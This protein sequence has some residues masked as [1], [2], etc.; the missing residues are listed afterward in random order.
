MPTTVEPKLSPALQ[1]FSLKDVRLLESP[2]KH[3][4]EMNNQ[5]LLDL[6]PDRLL[7]RFREFNGL[8]PKAPVYGGWE[9]MTIS[10]H[11]LGHYLT[12]IAQAYASTGEAVFKE[13]VDYI[14]SEL[15]L[16]Q[17]TR[18]T[19]F[20][21]AIP[22]QDE[23][24]G[25]LKNGIL[26]S[27]GFDLNGA[28]VPWYTQHKIIAG[29][30]DAYELCDSAEALEIARKFGYWMQDITASL[31]PEQWQQ[32]LACEHGG[33]NESF[34]ELYQ[35]TGEKVFLEIAEK[36]YHEAIL[37]PL[38]KGDPLILVGKHCNTQVPKI[39][40]AERIHALTG[41]ESFGTISRTFWNTIVHDHT[42]A[43]GGNSLNEHLGHPKQL[44]DRLGKN[45]A[46]TC[47][48][49]NL[50]KLTRELFMLQPTLEL[51]DFYERALYNHILAS[52]N[53]TTGMVCYFVPLGTGEQKEYSTPFDSFWCCV[54]TGIENHS[55]Y[56]DSIY[57]HDESS[58]WINLF[59]PSQLHWAEKQLKLRLETKFPESNKVTITI[60][61]APAHPIALNIRIPSWTKNPSF[62]INKNTKIFDQ[63]AHGF[64]VVDRQWTKGDQLELSLP[65]T[66]RTEPIPGNP[67]CVAFLYG[68]ILLASPMKPEITD[69]TIFASANATTNSLIEK[70]S[71]HPLEFRSKSTARPSDIRLIPFYQTHD[72]RYQVYF[73]LFTGPDWK[74]KEL[75]YRAQQQQ[76]ADL[77]ART[78]DHIQLGEMQPERDHNLVADSSQPHN[79]L[80]IKWRDATDGGSFTFEMTVDPD[81]SH[82]LV[83]RS[84]GLDPTHHEYDIFIDEHLLLH[85]KPD[86]TERSRMFDQ[87][88]DIRSDWTSGKSKIAIKFQASSGKNTC[89]L[90]HATM[91][92]K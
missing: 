69:A 68:P 28:W 79:W 38:A 7:S 92:R 2:F 4:M 43:N 23:V 12:A 67:S 34:A 75:T 71:D 33:I 50:L 49:Y 73:N 86:Y 48:T 78:T 59:I 64:A 58:L 61:E 70:V 62:K 1:A 82:Q 87:T 13:R 24:F 36:F 30:I 16:V 53:P 83:L 89:A 74:E 45:T 65:L 18:G 56:G 6:E 66:T 14:V 9:S 29:L 20:F 60:E 27:S 35:I 22:N 40:G 77:K 72:T 85:Q 91:I 17:D 21:G 63:K 57:F 10:G 37:T 15:K 88:F 44:H 46:E 5:W 51:A 54:G 81:A 8:A 11:T 26:K 19:G 52:Q 39:I 80:D 47:N 3:A 76:L 42:Y 41:Q 84:W 25:N 31:S 32:M 90:S 55:K